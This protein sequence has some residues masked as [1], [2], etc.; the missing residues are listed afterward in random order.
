MSS[1]RVCSSAMQGSQPSLHGQ[2][3]A[4]QL[5]ASVRRLPLLVLQ[6]RSAGCECKSAAAKEICIQNVTA[7]DDGWS[8][9]FPCPNSC[10][11]KVLPNSSGLKCPVVDDPSDC[12]SGRCFSDCTKAV[13]SNSC[14]FLCGFVDGVAYAQC[15]LPPTPSQS[16]RRH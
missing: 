13:S 4:V 7:Y 12:P 15:T 2:K 10:N 8:G 5:E 16:R 11:F 3:A 14:V 9:A 1:I 6:A